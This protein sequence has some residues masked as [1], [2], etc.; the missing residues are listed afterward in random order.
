MLPR[1]LIFEKKRL[2]LFVT[3]NQRNLNFCFLVK[4]ST[5]FTTHPTQRAVFS[6]TIQLTKH[7]ITVFSKIIEKVSMID[8]FK[9]LFYD[10]TAKQP[11]FR[12]S[13]KAIAKWFSII[14]L[15]YVVGLAHQFCFEFGP[16]QW[17]LANDISQWNLINTCCKNSSYINGQCKKI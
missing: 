5:S 14:K 8:F 12:Q 17:N 2:S 16:L 3:F 13:R 10:R 11:T 7:R 9:E 4:P 1:V 15:I 6:R